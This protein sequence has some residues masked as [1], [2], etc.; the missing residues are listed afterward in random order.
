MDC[1]WEAI[2][3][4]RIL[5]LSV[6]ALKEGHLPDHRKHR[7]WHCRLHLLRSRRPRWRLCPRLVGFRERWR[8]EDRSLSPWCLFRRYHARRVRLRLETVSDAAS[9]ADSWR[10][11]TCSSHRRK[12]LKSQC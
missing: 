11:Y 6:V 7:G 3:W 8:G 12:S 9:L 1:A 10:T 5:A 4:P 2:A